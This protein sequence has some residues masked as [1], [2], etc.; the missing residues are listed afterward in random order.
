MRG[1]QGPASRPRGETGAASRG[2][3]VGA[4][5]APGEAPSADA[6]ATGVP[7]Q[8]APG[9]VC[10]IPNGPV[11]LARIVH[12]ERTCGVTGSGGAETA[13]GGVWPLPPG[14]R[15]SNQ[16]RN[17]LI[18]DDEADLRA[19]VAVLLQDEGYAVRTAC[20][21]ERALAAVTSAPPDL[22]LLDLQMPVMDGSAFAA[23]YHRLA[24]PHAPI[25][26]CS[27]QSQEMLTNG[28]RDAPFLR[29]PFDAERLLAL[30]AT[31]LPTPPADLR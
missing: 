18:I 4:R 14:V 27:T 12:G 26:V 17:I 11:I 31:L 8:Q 1:E 2:V 5:P 30:V 21:G 19:A 25:V 22:I 3:R 24:G 16:G 13:A 20:D 23:A 6:D 10:A 28:L 7:A 15:M 29:K 9:P